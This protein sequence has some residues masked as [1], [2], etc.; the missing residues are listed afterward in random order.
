MTLFSHFCACRDLLAGGCEIKAMAD[1]G[2]PAVAQ[3]VSVDARK[4]V[5]STADGIFKVKSGGEKGASRKEGLHG[6]SRADELAHVLIFMRKGSFLF[7]ANSDYEISAR[8]KFRDPVFYEDFGFAVRPRRSRLCRN[9]QFRLQG[10]LQTFRV[11]F[12][13]MLGAELLK[14]QKVRRK[15]TSLKIVNVLSF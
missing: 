1:W 9:S 12:S 5:A 14:K 8:P 10:D 2:G 3:G 7:C 11:I 6:N 13:N 4:L 15:S